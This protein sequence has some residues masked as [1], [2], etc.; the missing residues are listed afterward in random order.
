MNQSQTKPKTNDVTDFFGEV[1]SSYSSNQAAEDGILIKTNNLIIN[2]ITRTVY[3]KC[4]EP[5]I[6]PSVLTDRSLSGLPFNVPIQIGKKELI[7]EIPITEAEKQRVT[8]KLLDKLLTSAIDEV[9]KLNREDWMY[10]LKDCRGW[11][12]W[13]CQNETGKYT[14]MFPEDY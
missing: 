9:R 12:L 1:I 3:E 5:F 7:L 10:N 4:I 8:K 13:V 6:N 14:L 2:F 11:N